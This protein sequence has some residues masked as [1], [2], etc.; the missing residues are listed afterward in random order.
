MPEL[1][2]VETVVRT[3]EH[4]IKDE[5]IL[6]VTIRY[7]G[8]IEGN[9]DTFCRKM[10]HQ[11]F[12][13][14]ARRGKYL[15][16]YMDDVL[17]VSHLRMEGKYYLQSDSEPVQKHVHVIFQLKNHKQL[18]YC[19]TRKFGRMSILPK[20]TDLNTFHD[21]GPEPFS[22]QFSP[23]YVHAVC[24]AKDEPIKTLLLD[25]SFVAGIGNIYADEI[26]FAC[27]I[28]PGRSCA[29]LTWNDCSNMVTETRLI[30]H[31]AIKA[32]GTT[33]RTY[34][35]SLG[36]TGLFQLECMVHEQKT[37]KVCGAEIKMKRLG[38]R[39]SYYCPNCQ[40]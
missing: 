14:F 32:G 40:K 2:E 11:H 19:D 29:R 30:L 7:R 39:S 6:G 36:V 1:P 38:G 31:A 13:R 17:F 3:L 21:L 20:D 18:R 4:Q 5:E 37:C 22:E 35:S 26:C 33:I 15:L 10:T 27:G 12:R 23:E 25:Q 16:F 24:K 28:R 8:I 34:T 9:P